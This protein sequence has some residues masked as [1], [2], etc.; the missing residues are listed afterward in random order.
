MGRRLV[1]I[2]FALCLFG[3]TTK[4]HAERRVALLI[5]NAAYA[6]A[7]LSNP[8]NDVAAMKATLIAAGFD[9]VVAMTN[10]SR[11][12]MSR[13]LG[14]FQSKASGAGIALVFFS[15][16]GMEVGGTNYL[17]P[18]D[19]RLASERDAKFEAI[20]LDD[21]LDALSGAVELRVV[22][23]DACRDNP[24][25][26]Q[27]ARSAQRGFASKG[28]ARI[29]DAQMGA[30]TVIAYA[31]APGKTASD[32]DGRNSPFTA[33]LIKHLATPGLAIQNAMIRVAREVQT[34]TKGEQSPYV[35]DHI[36]EEG[37]SLVAAAKPD[38]KTSSMSDPDA[39]ALADYTISKSLATVAAWDAF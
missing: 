34:T 6:A 36:T 1:M 32:G 17:I 21:V 39:E 19:A 29:D 22:L 27:M 2:V 28:L 4:A 24:F 13:A 31:A 30:N 8:V 20:P 9:V 7:P 37:L 35:E 33:A 15:G 11:P 14:D 23:L 18:T 16:H 38:A 12:E 26:H 10:L 5:G 3:L 25:T